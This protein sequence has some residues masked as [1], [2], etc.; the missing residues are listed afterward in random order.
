MRGWDGTMARDIPQ[1]L[2]FIAWIRALDR[3]LLADELGDLY[4]HYAGL[5]TQTIKT[6]LEREKSWCDDKATAVQ[7][8]CDDKVAASL[9][10]AMAELSERFGTDFTRWKWGDAHIVHFDHPVLGRLPVIGRLFNIRLPVD[11]GPYTLNRGMIRIS[12]D[13][14]YASVHGAGYRAVYDLAARNRSRYMISPG[15]SGNWLSSHYDDLAER[16]RN[17]GWI[18]LKTPG[19]D[20]DVLML[21]PKKP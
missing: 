20:S 19:D 21:E 10:D 15:Q 16:W 13:T 11:G 12:T 6:V 1:P 9:A 17:G 2:I 3:H 5:N 4:A 7:E 8:S 14:P 18:T